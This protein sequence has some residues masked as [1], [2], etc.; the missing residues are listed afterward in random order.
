MVGSGFHREIRVRHRFSMSQNTDRN[1]PLFFRLFALTTLAVLAWLIFYPHQRAAD[2]PPLPE[3]LA[4]LAQAETISGSAAQRRLGRLHGT[5]IGFE[6]A[7]QV[8]YGEPGRMLV[9]WLGLSPTAEEARFL[10]REMDRRMSDTPFFSD[11][12]ELSI[13]GHQVIKVEGQGREHYYWLTGRHNYWLEA[14]GMDGR[15]AVRELL[16]E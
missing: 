14:E 4:G 1:S 16:R 2:P 6:Q 11:R 12:R 8:N 7:Y 15:A 10:Y 5:A 3:R 13:D 9:V